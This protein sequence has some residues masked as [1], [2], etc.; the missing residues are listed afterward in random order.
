MNG[1]IGIVWN[2]SKVDE[3]ELRDAFAAAAEQAGLPPEAHWF[4]TAEDDPGG[5]AAGR[6]LAAGCSLVIAA[7]G[8]GTVRAVA[9]RLGIGETGTGETGADRPRA[10]AG[11]VEL[12]IVPLGTGN[13]LAR[14]LDIPLGDKRAAFERALT[15]EGSALDLGVVAVPARSGGEAR[16]IGFVVMIGFGVDAQMI[17]E[18]D[19]ELKAKA[20]WLAYVES[21]GRAASGTESVSFT[22]TID[23]EPARE[24]RAHTVLVGNCGSLQGGIPLLPDAEPDDGELDLLVLSADDAASWLDTAR[25]VVWDNGL[26]RL[27]PG[28]GAGNADEDNTES[29]DS[30]SRLRA[31]RISVKLAGP[32]VL[33]VDGDTVGEVS[34]F[35]VWVLPGA[36]R[37]R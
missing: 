27:L 35:E 37:V 21:L 4:E 11:G 1:S 24:E 3:S 26:R 8:D 18:T 31:R 7:G 20:G 19:D 13:L 15:G 14:N 36:L 28:G 5:E 34:S 33:E 16:Q 22:L 9:S 10:G 2:P 29:S 6:A 12:G 30:V 25:N 23:D 32:R 17:E